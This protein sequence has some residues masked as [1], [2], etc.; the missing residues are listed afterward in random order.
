[1]KYN[2]E[3]AKCLKFPVKE[4]IHDYQTNNNKFKFLGLNQRF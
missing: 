1:M 3:N 4:G 2:L